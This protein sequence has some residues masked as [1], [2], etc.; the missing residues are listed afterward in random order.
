MLFSS[1]LYGPDQ[2]AIRAA[3]LALQHGV[4]RAF[5]KTHFITDNT[6]VLDI[7]NGIIHRQQLNHDLAHAELWSDIRHAMHQQS[8]AKC[9]TIS[10]YFRITWVPSHLTADDP[11]LLNGDVKWEHF[12]LN[13]GA[14]ELASAAAESHRAP[15][16]LRANARQRRREAAFIHRAMVDTIMARNTAKPLPHRAAGFG[17]ALHC[18]PG[19]LLQ[20]GPCLDSEAL[21]VGELAAPLLG[22]DGPFAE[23]LGGLPGAND[24]DDFDNDPFGHGGALDEDSDDQTAGS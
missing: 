5:D 19:Q 16:P 6:T 9:Y 1:R 21:A 11:L 18:G 3:I 20:Q 13:R 10:E 24:D 7:G 14:D 2:T 8:A 4:R 23:E 15:A 22:P 17:A 12:L